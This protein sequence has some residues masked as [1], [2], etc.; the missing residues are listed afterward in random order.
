MVH[1]TIWGGTNCW[2]PNTHNFSLTNRP[3]TTTAASPS[4]P[5]R[6]GS[7]YNNSNNGAGP[8]LAKTPGPA[9]TWPSSSS[10]SSSLL[11]LAADVRFA[12]FLLRIGALAPTL[13]PAEVIRLLRAL[14]RLLLAGGGPG[15]D[16]EGG[17][18]GGYYQQQQQRRGRGE[19]TV[20]LGE[21]AASLRQRAAEVMPLFSAKEL[22]L[23]VNALG[24]LPPSRRADDQGGRRFGGLCV[25]AAG[26]LLSECTPQGLALLLTGLPKL[27]R[28]DE[29]DAA[30][31]SG[32]GGGFDDD[33]DDSDDPPIPA[34]F[35]MALRDAVAGQLARGD[36]EVPFLPQD[37]AL[38]LNGF[39]ALG[40]HPGVAFLHAHAAR[41]S[42]ALARC[43]PQDIALLWVAYSRLGWSPPPPAMAA[44]RD[45]AWATMGTYRPQDFANVLQAMGRMGYD[46]GAAFLARA[47]QRLE[48]ALGRFNAH[49]LACVLHALAL[50]GHLPPPR[51]RRRLLGRV[52][53]GLLAPSV[54]AGGF[55]TEEICM[56]AHALGQMP[57]LA[58]YER[59]QR[60]EA[61]AEAEAEAED[62]E[63]AAGDSG[64][65]A[66][67]LAA[68][69][70]RRMGAL[71]PQD[72]AMSIRALSRIGLRPVPPTFL[73]A[74]ERRL[75]TAA[76][77][78]A[79]WEAALTLH[80]LG[81]LTLASAEGEG[82]AADA[83]AAGPLRSEA[84]RR[85]FRQ[86]VARRGELGAQEVSLALN[87]AVHLGWPGE[88]M[89]R[90]LLEQMEDLLEARRR[91]P[92]PS[93]LLRRQLP[94]EG[95]EGKGGGVED[96]EA[97]A[98]ARRRKRL[99]FALEEDGGGPDALDEAAT[100]S[101]QE[102]DMDGDEDEE[103]P[104]LTAQGIAL[105]L[106][107]LGHLGYAPS[108]RL[109]RLLPP[110]V[111]GRLR[112][113]EF[114]AMDF[115]MSLRGLANLPPLL[116][117]PFVLALA[118]RLLEGLE[119]G[120]ATGRLALDAQD[121]AMVV[122]ALAKLGLRRDDDG[123]LL[124]S[125][126]AALRPRLGQA[127]GQALAS[128]ANA[129]ARLRFRPGPA[130]MDALEEEALARLG[131]PAEGRA[132]AAG[133][134]IDTPSLGLLLWSLAVLDASA[135][136]DRDRDG[137]GSALPPALLERAAAARLLPELKAQLSLLE[138]AA[139][140]EGKGPPGKGARPASKG[141]DK[142]A[143]MP[144]VAPWSPQVLETLLCQTLQV[145]MYARQSPVLQSLRRLDDLHAV[146]S[147]AWARVAPR[148]A[149]P[150]PSALHQE[151]MAALRAAGARF[152]AEQD[153]GDGGV[154]SLDV[155]LEPEPGA[156]RPV[157]LEV[158]GPTHYFADDPGVFMGDTV[159]K[160][161]L[162]AAERAEDGSGPRWGAVLS[163]ALW[164]WQG[165]GPRRRDKIALIERKLD[166]AGLALD[167]FRLAPSGGAA[168]AAAAA[169]AKQPAAP[170]R[171]G[172]KESSSKGGGNNNSGDS[173]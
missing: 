165:A 86:A 4:V 3:A 57:E 105:L 153:A 36:E 74:A 80:A 89:V 55:K 102:D 109:Q 88:G 10:S 122:N 139:E 117:S 77:A 110:A 31:D 17:G 44:M 19:M 53:V 112:A 104:A 121:I 126:A 33:D 124:A 101:P 51:V 170:P 138:A 98:R 92:A 16:D 168:A 73:A 164:E 20:L 15:S 75:P 82:E 84:A 43:R 136:W 32:D 7:S 148:R 127:S 47:V 141:K 79:G 14:P 90:G 145:L 50:L 29:V 151:V 85:L 143:A 11:A 30:V 156:L 166:S 6:R 34:P 142:S 123:R 125:L 54:A 158:D 163:V 63:A 69:V 58:Q 171:R 108:R 154:F 147:K 96:A 87:S 72:L 56:V 39:T 129:F 65:I 9:A 71:A 172:P 48:P 159:F 118:A 97:A 8:R 146:A 162:L 42:A 38:I 119:R 128:A 93:S 111:A 149:A 83:A 99:P 22:P 27:F 132:A 21:V 113:G 160:Q 26:A 140:R 70:E 12:R 116:G 167:Y 155:V 95:E 68:A 60:S 76:G 133:G 130:F 23:L 46:P 41:V 66:Q 152:A 137:D 114:T 35:L 78:L 144:A 135:L 100:T 169:G 64:G 52:R 67:C 115:G 157:V 5:G 91:S 150:V 28:D 120:V 49:S 25:A 94:T 106:G 40:F 173:K 1:N 62:D 24:K 134:S 161:R 2:H 81:R 37:L 61:T 131:R 45:R 18:G 107:A 103:E 59:Q 13:E